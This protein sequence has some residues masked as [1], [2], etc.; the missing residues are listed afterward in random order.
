[1]PQNTNAGIAY[2]FVRTSTSGLITVNTDGDVGTIINA[3]GVSATG[4]TLDS[5]GAKLSVISMGNANKWATIHSQNI[6]SLI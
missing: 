1:M 5:I 3:S 6:T 2:T 4:I